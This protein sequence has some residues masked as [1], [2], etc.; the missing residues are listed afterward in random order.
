MTGVMGLV[1]LM[2]HLVTM[3]RT[4]LIELDYKYSR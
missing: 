3:L 4:D 1:M 2:K